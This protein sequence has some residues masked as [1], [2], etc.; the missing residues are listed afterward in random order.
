MESG[1]NDAGDP[2]ADHPCRGRYCRGAVLLFAG[3]SLLALPLVSSADLRPA[4]L[5]RLLAEE[6]YEE[7]YDLAVEHRAE[8]EGESSS[9]CSTAARRSMRAN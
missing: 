8:L 4:D 2:R 1:G 6:R 5:E 3:L 7:A 9:I